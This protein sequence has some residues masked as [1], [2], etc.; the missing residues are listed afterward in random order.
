MI[1][2]Y[3][4]FIHF[5]EE[6]WLKL[7]L[8]YWDR[9][10]RIVPEGFRTH[11]SED[12]R[13]VRG[14]LDAV[15]DTRPSQGGSHIVSEFVAFVSQHAGQLRQ[16]Y[17]I[18]KSYSWKINEYTQ[19][20]APA[21]TNARFGYIYDEKLGN[22]LTHLL[23][24]EGLAI[25][26]EW[27]DPRWIGVHP[28][29]SAV[30][31]TALAESIAGRSGYSLLSDDLTAHVAVGECSVNGFSQVLLHDVL[32]QPITEPPNLSTALAITAI[33]TVVP[34]KLKELPIGKII[35]LRKD[36]GIELAEFQRWIHGSAKQLQDTAGTVQSLAA[37]NEHLIDF[38]QN[39]VR[40]RL[41]RLRADLKKMKFE[42]ISGA[43][44]IKSPWTV[45]GTAAA[46][47]LHQPA[48]AVGGVAFSAVAQFG[49]QTREAGKLTA[50]NP[51]AYLMY[52]QE[53]LA[54]K[55][56]MAQISTSIRK[57]TLGV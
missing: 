43:L 28:D 45:G 41:R 47:Y 23:L 27:G 48:L 37:M 57:L 55:S 5:R 13:R 51:T 44:G 49:K 52:A 25:R 35:K 15:I 34:Q 40:P 38:E 18:A 33:R 26:G 6:D 22:Q 3:Y 29:I 14:E 36:Y 11:D 10:A 50:A 21:G 54:P 19:S 42:T 17:D 30:Y 9:I 39:Q 31:M 12:V 56:L 8:I 4:P 16:K 32:D 53:R 1:G 7:S 20:R 24:S 2:L 46:L